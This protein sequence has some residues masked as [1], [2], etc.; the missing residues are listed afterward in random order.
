MARARTTAGHAE[1]TAELDRVAWNTPRRPGDAAPES[2][3]RPWSRAEAERLGADGGSSGTGLSQRLDWSLFL[4]RYFPR[5]RRHD[6]E[7]LTAYGEYRS[8]PEIGLPS[9]TEGTA[10]EESQPISPEPAAVDA[11]EDDGGSTSDNGVRRH[12]LGPSH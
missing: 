6:L 5:R 3:D 1:A 10:F 2:P 12:V 7:A 11:W 9:A 4:A 8:S